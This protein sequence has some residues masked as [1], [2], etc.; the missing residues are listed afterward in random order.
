MKKFLALGVITLSLLCSSFTPLPYTATA[1]ALKGRTAS[2]IRVARGIV[3]AD[4]RLHKLGSKIY[5][6]AGQYSGT[7]TV[8]DTG[9]HVKGRRIDIWMPSVRECKK[10][11]RRKVFVDKVH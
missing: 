9:G 11:G 1:Y 8:A 2:G 6:N 5:V 4:P 3:A 7:Y 10:F